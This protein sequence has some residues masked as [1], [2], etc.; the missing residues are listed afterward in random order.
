MN[1]SYISFLEIWHLS[2]YYLIAISGLT[3]ILI[4]LGYKVALLTKKDLKDKYDFVS[5]NEIKLYKLATFALGIALFCFLNY[6]RQ[7]TIQLAPMWF[8]VRLF[9]G[10]CISTLFIYIMILILQYYYPKPLSQKLKRLRYTPRVNPT[11]GN[12]MKLLSEEEEDAYLDEGM[13]AEEN[14]FSVDYD[15]WVDPDS[16]YVKIEKYKGHLA[17]R[18]CDRCGFQTLKLSF[19][20]I[21]KKPSV[22]ADGEIKKEYECTYCGRIK[23]DIVRLSR[24]SSPEYTPDNPNALIDNPMKSISVPVSVSVEIMSNKGIMKTYQ[25]QDTNE[26]SKFLSEFEFRKLD[27]PDV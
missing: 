13:Q 10:I 20:E 21:I 8:F 14:V 25:F 23:R 16:E 26:A 22:N 12:F 27:D 15:V 5:V 2:M 3:A 1:E 4:Y 19:E 7:D 24:Q 9:T 11:N 6:I 18:E 17:A